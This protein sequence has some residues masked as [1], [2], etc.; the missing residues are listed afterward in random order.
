M[1]VIL[2]AAGSFEWLTGVTGRTAAELTGALG[3]DLKAPCRVKFFPYLSGER[4]PHNDALVRGAFVGL[5]HAADATV[6][7]QAVLEGVAYALR[8]NLEALAAAGTVLDR[9]VAIGGGSRSRYWLK[10]IA[11][12]LNI[13]IDVPAQGEFGAAVG[14]ARLGLIAAAGA[15]PLA[16]CKAPALAETIEPEAALV[17]DFSDHHA[18]WQ[19]LYPSI[20]GASS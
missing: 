14:A 8:D 10:V 9:M 1:G 19:A 4:T 5:D 13:P 3:E 6:L 20:K 11:T 7:A 12:A 16:V 15:D 2:S 18:R 17:S